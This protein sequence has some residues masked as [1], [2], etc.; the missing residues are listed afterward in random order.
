MRTGPSASA[1]AALT[2]SAHRPA[3]SLTTHAFGQPLELGVGLGPAATVIYKQDG[4]FLAHRVSSLASRFRGPLPIAGRDDEVLGHLDETRQSQPGFDPVA[5]LDAPFALGF[6]GQVFPALD[7][8]ETAAAA[9]TVRPAG[10]GHRETL[11]P[12]GL[13]EVGASGHASFALRGQE[14]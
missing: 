11:L 14:S 2:A 12:G 5:C 7:D 13:E 6:G 8:F 3:G 10:A 4:S 9:D 1:A